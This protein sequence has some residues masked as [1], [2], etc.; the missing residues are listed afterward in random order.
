MSKRSKLSKPIE[1]T[2][3]R[4][5]TRKQGDVNVGVDAGHGLGMQRCIRCLARVASCM[6]KEQN[7]FHVFQDTAAML[8]LHWQH[9]HQAC[10]CI[11]VDGRRFCSDPF[12]ESQWGLTGDIVVNGRSCG[13][14][15]VYYMKAFP[16]ADE[17]P[18]LKDERFLIDGV[19]SVLALGIE[20]HRMKESLCDSEQKFLAIFNNAVNGVLLVERYSKRCCMANHVFCEM[21]GYTLDEVPDLSLADFQPDTYVTDQLYDP[22]VGQHALRENVPLL[23]KDRSMLRADVSSF[24][25]M[26]GEREYLLDIFKDVTERCLVESEHEQRLEVLTI[27]HNELAKGL[28]VIRQDVQ[29]LQIPSGT[30]D[31]SAE[32]FAEG[33]NR[34]QTCLDMAL[35]YT[36]V[37][38]V[39]DGEEWIDLNRFFAEL[40]EERVV[41]SYIEV[42]CA[43]N[44][45][46]I[47]VN[48]EAWRTMW[49]YLFSHAIKY[50][51]DLREILNLNAERQPDGWMLLLTG[52]TRGAIPKHQ[53]EDLGLFRT[54]AS[55]ESRHLGVGLAIAR[56]YALL[57]GGEL[58]VTS[59][60]DEGSTLILHLPPERASQVPLQSAN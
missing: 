12:M 37:E 7:L 28:E 52:Y 34:V 41:G 20:A 4:W 57:W 44:L 48:R 33:L 32:A 46:A 30:S 15:T 40:V 27:S 25:I 11:E 43:E 24:P 26:V 42:R 60:A 22:L 1:S 47:F 8:P 3:R 55:G 5:W 59:Q 9:A 53:H 45:P 14:V 2:R 31:V 10:A 19:A 16:L 17:G 51:N 39:S 21:L 36:Q 23:R 58:R 50:A 18:F 54:L 13:K 38:L 49:R 56:K 6:Q 35:A 29:R